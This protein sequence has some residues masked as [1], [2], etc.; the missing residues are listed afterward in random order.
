MELNATILTGES[1][2]TSPDVL[3]DQIFFGSVSKSHINQDSRTQLVAYATY[4]HI[5][6]NFNFS[7]MEKRGS[8]GRGKRF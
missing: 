1:V 2:P 7:V 6:I 4:Y 8:N 3:L 5:K